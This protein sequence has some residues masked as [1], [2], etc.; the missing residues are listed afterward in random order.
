MA[1][2][3]VGWCGKSYKYEGIGFLPAMQIILM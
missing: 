3:A 1:C 2:Q